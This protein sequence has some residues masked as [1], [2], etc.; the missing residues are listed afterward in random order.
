MDEK[1]K[2]INDRKDLLMNMTKTLQAKKDK[3]FKLIPIIPENPNVDLLKV[4]I[5]Y[6]ETEKVTG[7]K[8]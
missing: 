3:I 2:T 6:P 7:N 5:H 1:I 8:S 4:P